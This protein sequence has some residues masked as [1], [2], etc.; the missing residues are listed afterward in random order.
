[1]TSIVAALAAVHPVGPTFPLLG[2]GG[3]AHGIGGGSAGVIVIVVLM[4]VRI[5]MRSRGGGRGRR[6]PWR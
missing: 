2:F 1:V 5:Y 6:G 3:L 4:A